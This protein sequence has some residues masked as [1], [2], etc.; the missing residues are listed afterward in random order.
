MKSRERK[1]RVKKTKDKVLNA[2]I[3]EEL[4]QQLRERAEKLDMP[5][6]QLVR[7]ILQGTVDLVGNFSG[8]VEQL[9]SEMVDDVVSLKRRAQTAVIAGRPN[10]LDSLLE[11]ILGWQRITVNRPSQCAITGKLLE[12][13]AIAHLGIRNDGQPS[14][15]V[16]EDSLPDI[17][18]ERKRQMNWLPMQ[19]NQAATCAHTGQHLGVGE[20]AYYQLHEGTLEIISSAAYEALAPKP[21]G[22]NQQET[23][24]T[25]PSSAD[26]DGKETEQ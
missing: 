21:R 16:S 11:K 18:N 15:V 2:R 19:L 26:I 23:L 22:D 9:V 1:A 6:S 25:A 10:R 7:N 13:G 17:L 20:Q 3:S 4:E 5:V 12:I 14:V 24:D 8:N